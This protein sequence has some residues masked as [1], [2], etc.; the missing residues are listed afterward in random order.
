MW[1]INKTYDQF[2]LMVI[3]EFF[4]LGNKILIFIDHKLCV[5]KQVI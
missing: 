4:L 2:Q 1:H 3:D 5:I